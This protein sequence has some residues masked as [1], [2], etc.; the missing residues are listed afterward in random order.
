MTVLY[1][2]N[3]LKTSDGM[4]ETDEDTAREEFIFGEGREG[5]EK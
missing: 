2:Q 3:D 5:E 4:G 1:Y